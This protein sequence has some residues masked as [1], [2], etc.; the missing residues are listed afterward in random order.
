MV[1]IMKITIYSKDIYTYG[2]MLVGGILKE[3]H[4]HNVKLTKDIKNKKLFL[5]SDIV[6]FSLYS[7][8]NIVDPVIKDTIDYL[9]SKNIKIYIAGPVSA[10]PGIILGELN[11]DG[12]ILGEGE[13]KT[14]EIINGST[15]GLAYL[16]NGEI[17][18]NKPKSK[19]DL[20]FSKIYVP[21]DI[22]TQNVR[23]AN[24]YIETHRGCLG[25]CTFCQVPEFFGRDIRS[26]PIELIIEEVKELKKNGVK[27][28]AI[29]GG[30][31][32]LYNFKNTVNK[33]KFI[34]MIES[35]SNIIGRGNLSVPDMRVDYVDEEVL[36]A[37]KNYSIGWVFYGIESG[38]DKLLNSMKK[39]TNT[40]KNLKAIELAKDC[41]VKVAGS[42][43]VGHPKE[44]EVDFLMT[45]DFIVDAELDDVF[46]SA[47]EPIP[48][49]ELCN[50]VL[51]TGMDKNPTFMPHNGPYRKYGL[52]EN[53]ARAYDLMLHSE[54]WK[55]T[56]RM[57][58]NTLSKV[59]LDEA[60]MQGSDI[61]KATELIFKYR[62]F[63][64]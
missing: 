2:A 58:T 44:K 41:G 56:P 43:I 54:M 37:I 8:L 38:S 64:I 5:K 3:K 28:I 18:I 9:K 52:K 36:N 27:R 16:E 22:E 11:I 45:K 31:G 30:T 42:F 55:S 14:P 60:K 26:K 6:I 23:G 12:V 46:V 17:I 32:S 50:E 61:R 47:A 39:G 48:R 62:D 33:N 49:T 25:H 59:Y 57:I 20:D 10:Y 15:E 19:P 51:T 13:I 21:K 4:N 7:T 34:E 53:E 63:L 40:K 35:V 29:S 1:E 24:V